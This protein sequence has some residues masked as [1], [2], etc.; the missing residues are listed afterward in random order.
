MNPNEPLKVNLPLSQ[1]TPSVCEECGNETF[2]QVLFL[3]RASKFLTGAQQDTITPIPT[4]ACAKCN[5]VNQE[6]Q[7]NLTE[8][9]EA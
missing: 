2:T 3:R 4:F 8:T 9:P 7:L 5:H 1:T 6:F